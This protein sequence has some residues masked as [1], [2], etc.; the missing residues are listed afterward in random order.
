[1]N[2]VT[3]VQID[4]LKEVIYSIGPSISS[5]RDDF[6]NLSKNTL[7]CVNCAGIKKQLQAAHAKIQSLEGQICRLDN[8][9]NNKLVT[10]AESFYERE[11]NRTK[12]RAKAR[13]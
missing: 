12:S 4:D 2:K 10:F 6:H 13:G 1:M 8:Q 5:L 3:Q 9:I 7:G 11:N